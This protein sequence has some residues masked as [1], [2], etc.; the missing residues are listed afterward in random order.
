M[1]FEAGARL[2]SETISKVS[3]VDITIFLMGY[4]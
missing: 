2:M 4:N 1:H 3:T